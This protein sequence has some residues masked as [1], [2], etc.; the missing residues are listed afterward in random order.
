MKSKSIQVSHEFVIEYDGRE[1]YAQVSATFVRDNNYGADADG[2]RGMPMDF[3]EDIFVESI[4][5]EP[6]LDEEPISEEQKKKVSEMAE[7][8]A[9]AHDWCGDFAERGDDD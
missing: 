9:E 1:F 6:T 2:N 3:L 4:T 7:K 8:E 5:T